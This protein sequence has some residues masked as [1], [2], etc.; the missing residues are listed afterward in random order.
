MYTHDAPLETIPTN[1]A[2]A[3]GAANRQQSSETTT[4]AAVLTLL[5][6]NRWPFGLS[7]PT[8]VWLSP[9]PSSPRLAFYSDA[10]CTI[11]F[12]RRS[13]SA[14][15]SAGWPTRLSRGGVL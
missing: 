9:R 3:P 2:L 1:T 14:G 5:P 7:T 6:W 11:A 13:R 8:P 10:L 4:T 12:A 15:W